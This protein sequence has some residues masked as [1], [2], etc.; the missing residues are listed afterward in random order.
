MRLYFE[1][2]K[3]SFQRQV[4]YRGATLA[5]FATNLFF[6]ALRAS[7]L[8]AVFGAQSSLAGYSLR[9]AFTYT[10]FTQAMIAATA[11]WGWFDM[12]RS[13]KSGEVA[14]DLSRPFDYYAFWLAQ[15]I[16]RSLYQL[17]ARGVTIMLAF[18]LMFGISLPQTVGHWLLAAASVACALLLSF[19][20]RFLISSTAFWLTDAIGF[21][22]MA[23]FMMTFPSG[24]MVP[25]AFMPDWLQAVCR[26]TPFPSFVDTPVTV[27]LGHARGADALNLIAVQ[28]IWLAVLAVLG[29]FAAEVGRRKLTIQGG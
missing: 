28:T 15:D 4:A 19:A 16:G 22:R 27:F 25:L 20:W 9:D 8:V 29:R 18:G 10:G 6:G 12:I 7:V 21:A 17:I 23:Y 24:F 26:A 14:S 13:I 11:L 1:L 5:G 2:A 3:K